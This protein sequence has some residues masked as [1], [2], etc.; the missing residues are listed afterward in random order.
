MWPHLCSRLSYQTPPAGGSVT[1]TQALS[2]HSLPLLA[3]LV[4]FPSAGFGFLSLPVV[5]CSCGRYPLSPPSR[6]FKILINLRVFYIPA[7]KHQLVLIN[8]SSGVM[9]AVICFKYDPH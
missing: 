2:P 8:H 5:V 1:S 9:F 4:F 6:T 3:R 7:H